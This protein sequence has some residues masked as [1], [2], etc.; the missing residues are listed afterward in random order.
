M[1]SMAS[2]MNLCL[3]NVLAATFCAADIYLN[4]F[5]VVVVEQYFVSGI[6]GIVGD[7]SVEF[8]LL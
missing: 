8:L 4:H 6:A 3:C 1:Q 7:G 5:W 2:I